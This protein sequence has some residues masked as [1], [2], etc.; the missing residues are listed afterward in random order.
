MYNITHTHPSVFGLILDHE[1]KM[2][3]FFLMLILGLRLDCFSATS[4][5]LLIR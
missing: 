2:F 3:E 4:F 5:V 1:V